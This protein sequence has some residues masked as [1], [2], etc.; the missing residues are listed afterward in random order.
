MRLR[1]TT[2][3]FLVAAISITTSVRTSWSR[4]AGSVRSPRA[5]ELS[6]PLALAAA[7]PDKPPAAAAKPKAD[8]STWAKISPAQMAAAK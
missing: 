3:F 5:R 4:D 1:I 2:A 6:E 8:I 7:K